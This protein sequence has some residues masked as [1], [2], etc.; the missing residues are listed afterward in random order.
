ML[1]ASRPTRCTRIGGKRYRGS[2]KSTDK[3]T[4][5]AFEQ[6]KHDEAMEDANKAR[7]GM[8]RMTVWDLAQAWLAVSEITHADH[9]GNLSRVRKLFGSS[10]KLVGK[11]WV[12]SE[13]DRY[14]LPKDLMVHEVTQAI[15]SPSQPETHAAQP[16]AP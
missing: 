6:R 16:R 14:G 13:N 11:K 9:R 3:R 4:A 7:L 15:S 8:K 5:T 12:E 1:I 10:L 2:T